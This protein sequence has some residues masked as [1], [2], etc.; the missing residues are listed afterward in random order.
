M[1]ICVQLSAEGRSV[2]PLEAGVIGEQ[3]DTGAGHS[4]WVL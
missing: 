1:C 3:S 2:R 4:T